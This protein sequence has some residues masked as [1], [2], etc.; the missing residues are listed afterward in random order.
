MT[1]SAANGRTLFLRV[2]SLFLGS[3]RHP[4][5]LLLA[6]DDVI[7]GSRPTPASLATTPVPLC[8]YRFF[9]LLLLL[10]LLLSFEQSPFSTRRFPFVAA[11]FH[12]RG[13]N[14]PP[15]I[16]RPSLD[17]KLDTRDLRRSFRHVSLVL[18]ATNRT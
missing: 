10:L 12:E 5:A 9:F 17:L 7:V 2:L 16:A 3:L 18:G 6:I 4:N 14:W 13:S 11:I 8:K 1:S 15:F